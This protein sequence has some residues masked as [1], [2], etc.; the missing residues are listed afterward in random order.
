MLL[1]LQ[2]TLA[3]AVEAKNKVL[4]EVTA[5]KNESAVLKSSVALKLN[6]EEEKEKRLCWFECQQ[7]ASFRLAMYL[8][9]GRFHDTFPDWKGLNL[10]DVARNTVLRVNATDREAKSRNKVIYWSRLT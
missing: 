3:D 10:G 6:R 1:K 5:L 2:K 9:A 7:T 4:P 8:M